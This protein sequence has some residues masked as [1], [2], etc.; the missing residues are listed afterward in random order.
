MK[1]TFKIF[2]RVRSIKK[3]GEVPF[4]IRVTLN[5]VSKWF[6]MDI[7]FPFPEVIKFNEKVE[8]GSIGISGGKR[9]RIK[10][11]LISLH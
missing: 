2:P 5:R 6:S 3:N 8:N 1:P 10:I 4:Y 9:W 11:L 7:S